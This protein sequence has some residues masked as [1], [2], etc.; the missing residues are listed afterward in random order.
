M[1]DINQM[2]HLFAFNVYQMIS[3][4]L[5]I[6]LVLNYAMLLELVQMVL[7]IVNYVIQ[8][9]HCKDVLLL[10]QVNVFNHVMVLLV[11]LNVLM[12]VH[13]VNIK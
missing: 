4:L 8:Q 3:T 12:F 7:N 6:K 13:K 5:K 2:Q 11:E 1:K 9:N 10:L